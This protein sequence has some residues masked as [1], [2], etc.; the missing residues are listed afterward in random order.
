LHNFPF[1]AQTGRPLVVDL[2]IHFLPERLE[3]NPPPPSALEASVFSEELRILNELLRT[4][5]FFLCA[6]EAKRGFWLGML[7]AN[8]RVNPHTLARGGDLRSLLAVVPELSDQ[9]EEQAGPLATFCA[10]PQHAPDQGLYVTDLERVAK[11]RG[12][13]IE[14]L[15]EFNYWYGSSIDRGGAIE[16][17]ESE[18][19]NLKAELEQYRLRK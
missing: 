5:D 12:E 11:D 9:D 15:L 4:G 2:A 1:L 13:V 19:R 14:G 3:T 6:S 10:N 18:V 7:F 8:H 17:L 16:Y